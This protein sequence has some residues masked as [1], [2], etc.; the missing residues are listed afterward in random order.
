MSKLKRILLAILLSVVIVMVFNWRLVTVMAPL[1][2][3]LV[4]PVQAETLENNTLIIPSVGLSAPI[5]PSMTDPT[6]SASWSVLRKDLKRGVSLAEKL[7]KP[8]EVGTTLITGHSSDWL[9]HRY[10]AVFAP[11]HYVGEGDGVRLRYGDQDF[12]YRIVEKK[13]VDPL[14]LKYF[15][16]EL[17]ETN[18]Q[19]RLALVTCTPLLTTAKRLVVIA[20]LVPN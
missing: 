1:T 18:D 16:E 4:E 7:P 14:D 15:Q 12:A 20:E 5:I 6:D 2:L 9:P 3:D 17:Q 10:A 19:H 13:V 11:L 8:G